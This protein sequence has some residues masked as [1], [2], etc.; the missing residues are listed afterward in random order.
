MKQT[1]SLEPC[2]QKAN[3]SAEV[4][5]NVACCGE[6]RQLVDLYDT[7]PERICATDVR[8]SGDFDSFYRRRRITFE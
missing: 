6:L 3:E 8:G 7:L 5:T 1:V 4:S 2:R